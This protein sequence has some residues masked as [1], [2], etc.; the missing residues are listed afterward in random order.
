MCIYVYTYV[1]MLY[2]YMGC[3]LILFKNRNIFICKYIY[4]CLFK[5]DVYK[6]YLYMNKKRF[7]ICDVYIY[8]Y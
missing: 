2:I 5:Y 8:K 7:C 1:Y 6:M 4:I 3:I